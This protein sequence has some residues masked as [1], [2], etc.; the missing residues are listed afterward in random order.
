MLN[1]SQ[2]KEKTELRKLIDEWKERF[3]DI[4]YK[5]QQFVDDVDKLVEK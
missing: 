5:S 4:C 1:R 2:E 3:D